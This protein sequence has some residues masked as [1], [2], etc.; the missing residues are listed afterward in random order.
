[1][2]HPRTAGAQPLASHHF[3][4][5]LCSRVCRYCLLSRSSLRVKE[6]ELK[7]DLEYATMSDD[8]IMVHAAVE[9]GKQVGAWS[10]IRQI[11]V[12]GLPFQLVMGHMRPGPCCMI[13]CIC[14]KRAVSS[15]LSKLLALRLC[16]MF[17]HCMGLWPFLF[18]CRRLSG[19][20]PQSSTCG[21]FMHCAMT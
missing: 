8:L 2:L 16:N 13:G 20:F 9:L 18:V 21:L 3:T 15:C 17:E 19:S 14:D 4:T 6:S 7:P 10:N 12:N 11:L 1:M 5:L